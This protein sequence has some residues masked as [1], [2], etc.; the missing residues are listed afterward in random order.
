MLRDVCERLMGIVGVVACCVLQR[1]TVEPMIRIES[2]ANKSLSFLGMEIIN[3]GIIQLLEREYVLAVAHSPL[4]REPNEP[5]AVISA[6][7]CVVG[8]LV[9]DASKVNRLSRDA[10]KIILG[11]RVVFDRKALAKS[12][13]KALK[14]RYRAMRIP[15]LDDLAGVSDV[16][17]ATIGVSAHKYLA[18]IAGWDP[19][20]A[21]LGTI[22]VGLNRS[23][24]NRPSKS[25]FVTH[26]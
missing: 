16:I 15:E 2:Q 18:K 7:D 4:L 3:D 20:D 9:W 21:K 1:S 5:M 13:G 17:S 24:T 19:T 10:D 26:E 8:T 25:G 22:L 11:E 23:A 12:K 6:G 14:F